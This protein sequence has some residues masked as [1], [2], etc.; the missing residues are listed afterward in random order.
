MYVFY[1]PR[2]RLFCIVSSQTFPSLPPVTCEDLVEGETKET[3]EK[4][5]IYC[6]EVN[7]DGAEQA[8]DILQ[9]PKQSSTIEYI[10]VIF[11]AE[12]SMTVRKAAGGGEGDIFRQ[13]HEPGRSWIYTKRIESAASTV[14]ACGLWR[15]VMVAFAKLSSTAKSVGGCGYRLLANIDLLSEEK[16]PTPRFHWCRA[17]TVLW[18]CGY[19]IYLQGEAVARS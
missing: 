12:F 15:V 3:N 14:P 5:G 10:C 17:L 4:E 13:K 11:P 6:S 9:A 16:P 19:S 18:V 1:F 8:Q 7:R 2:S